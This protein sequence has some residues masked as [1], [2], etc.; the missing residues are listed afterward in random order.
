MKEAVLTL[1]AMV[2]VGIMALSSKS[3]AR[4]IRNNNPGNIRWDRYT[5]WEGMTGADDDGFVIFSEPEYGIR[6]MTRIFKSYARRGITSV[7]DIVST[8]APEI[9]NNTTAYIDHVA[10]KLGLLVT[11]DVPPELYAQ[12]AEVIILHENGEQP[13]QIAT[14]EAGVE[15]A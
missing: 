7:A 9:E 15:M 10:R 13:Y 8:W 5:E 14:I 4:G 3:Q 6:A 1:A 2:G 11:D 12:L